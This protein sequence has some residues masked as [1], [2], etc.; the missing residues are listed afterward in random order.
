MYEKS[1]A[2]VIGLRI[3]QRRK[4]LGITQAELAEAIGVCDNQISNIENGKCFL[5]M[6]SFLK[7]C[8]A[9]DCTTDYL[10]S[11][12]VKDDLQD[13]LVDLLSLL[14]AEEQKTVWKLLDAYIHREDNT[15]V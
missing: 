10:C 1:N 13:N 4:A 11:G 6:S 7:I 9:L 8:D 14:S 12:M 15:L 5:R 2:I 3:M